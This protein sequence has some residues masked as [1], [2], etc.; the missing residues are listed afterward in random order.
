MDWIVCRLG[1]RGIYV[2]CCLRLCEDWL[3]TLAVSVLDVVLDCERRLRL[4]RSRRRRALGFVALRE[5][6]KVLV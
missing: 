3:D 6:L 2:W 1:V 5:D 4:L